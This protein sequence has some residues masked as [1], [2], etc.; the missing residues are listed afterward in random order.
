MNELKLPTTIRFVLSHVEQDMKDEY[1][2]I[3]VNT[4]EIFGYS[5]NVNMMKDNIK[6]LCLIEE[7]AFSVILSYMI[8]LRMFYAKTNTR[9]RPLTWASIKCAQQSGSTECGYYVM[10]FMQD[11]V[12]QKSITIID[13][14]T[15]QA[16]CTQSELYM[17]W[18]CGGGLCSLWLFGEETGIGE[19]MDGSHLEKKGFASRD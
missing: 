16:P 1:L 10:K 3:P 7:L 8:A 13:V 12:R 18:S 4:Q 9:A 6:Q 19:E 14:L 11:I 17:F 2:T 15:R 5:F